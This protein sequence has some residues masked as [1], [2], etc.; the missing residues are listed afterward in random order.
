M[1]FPPQPRMGHPGSLHPHSPKQPHPG[2]PHHSRVGELLDALKHEVEILYE[3]ANY[4]KH[5]RKDLESKRKLYLI[6]VASQ[7][8]EM[9]A[10]QKALY[11]LERIHQNIKIQYEDEVK[12][13]RYELV[14]FY[15]ITSGIPRN[16][17]AAVIIFLRYKEI[18]FIARWYGLY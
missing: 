7:I 15:R 12:R 10:F 17:V 18:K 8:Q 4:S 11:D 5:H 13:L 16:P 2:Q 14:R 1:S 9:S 3:E 6:L